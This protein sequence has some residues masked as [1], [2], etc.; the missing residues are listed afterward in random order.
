MCVSDKH[1]I[2]EETEQW[3]S[4]VATRQSTKNKSVRIA[5]YLLF[6]MEPRDGTVDY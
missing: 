5:F 2:P 3:P 1:T 4:T 6:N